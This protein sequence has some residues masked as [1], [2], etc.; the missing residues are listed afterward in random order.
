V[1]NSGKHG[2]SRAILTKAGAVRHTFVYGP[3]R[4]GTWD[5]RVSPLNG[6]VP[7]SDTR[8]SS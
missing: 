5:Q 1:F 6:I 7:C 4:A 8:T 3:L 2:F